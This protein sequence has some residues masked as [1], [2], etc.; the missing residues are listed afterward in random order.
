MKALNCANCGANLKYTVGSPVTVCQFCDSVNILENVEIKIENSKSEAPSYFEELK[1]RLMLPE[2]KYFISNWENNGHIQ[3][4]NIWI[5]NTEIFFKPYKITFGDLSTK[6]MKISDIIS[7]VI[8]NELLFGL[9]KILTITDKNGKVMRLQSSLKP[10]RR[11]LIITKIK[12]R[13]E[14]LI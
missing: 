1:P 2:E 12:E 4:G 5:S 7:M 6:F 9:C 8:T 14:N 10:S 3:D 11:D 13:K